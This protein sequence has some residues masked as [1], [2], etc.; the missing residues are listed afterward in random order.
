METGRGVHTGRLKLGNF[1][2]VLLFRKMNF[3]FSKI[4]FTHLKRS[5]LLH[6]TL[7]RSKVFVVR[8]TLH[9]FLFEK[10]SVRLLVVRVFT[11]SL[12]YVQLSLF[13]A[14]DQ[15]PPYTPPYRVSLTIWSFRNS[16]PFFLVLWFCASP[17]KTKVPISSSSS[18][19]R[20]VN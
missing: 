9:I 6:K 13:S 5:L 2:A 10:Y 12:C 7:H 1:Q 4:G 18:V 8:A 3:N 15:V 19:R 14:I 17:S 20:N 11:T 16:L